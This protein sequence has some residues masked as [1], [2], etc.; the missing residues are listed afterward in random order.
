MAGSGGDF[1]ERKSGATKARLS[2]PKLNDVLIIDDEMFDTNRL[3][4]T[5][6][7]LFGYSLEIRGAATLATALD[8]VLGKQPDLIFLDDILK[9]NDNAA[10]T[11]PF[12]R[13]ANF[14]GPIVVI[15]GQ[16]TR[17]RQSTLLACGATDVIHKDDVDSVRLS[18]SL[19]RVF[20]ASP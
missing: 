6:R 16:V 20:A 8:S 5:L 14:N 2:L 7:I 11:I 3:K 19:V 15:S 12:L 18:E 10:E 9:P 13:R 1:L 4:A 17:K